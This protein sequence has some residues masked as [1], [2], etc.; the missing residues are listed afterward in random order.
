MPEFDPEVSNKPK[1][2]VARFFNAGWSNLV[3]LMA[4]NAFFIL[5]NIPAIILAGVIAVYFV[6]WIA[7]HFIDVHS[8][9]DPVTGNDDGITAL[10]MDM[11]A[12]GIAN[13]TLRRALAQAKEHCPQ[14]IHLV[15]DISLPLS[16]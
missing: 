15:S 10:Q 13:D 8:Y 5:F 12:K 14:E 16:V 4:S 1:G 7:P 9:I 2:P 6:P 11:K 3:R